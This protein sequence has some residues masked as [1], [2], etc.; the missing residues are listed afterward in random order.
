MAS[1]R[2]PVLQAVVRGF[3]MR[4]EVGTTCLPQA[5]LQS[6]ELRFQCKMLHR[7]PLC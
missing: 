5:S 6:S 4:C 7:L 2:T 1:S 3:Y